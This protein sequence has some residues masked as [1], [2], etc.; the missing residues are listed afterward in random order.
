M[1]SSH[2]NE[3]VFFLRAHKGF[4]KRVLGGAASASTE[5]LLSK[6]RLAAV[7]VPEEQFVALVDGPYG[8]SYSDFAAFDTTVLVAGSTGVTFTL[9]ILLDIAYRASTQRLPL[10]SLVFIWM[11]KNTEWAVW[12]VHELQDAV[13]KLHAVG[14]E[15]EVKIYVTC[16]PSFTEEA[17]DTRKCGCDCDVRQGPCCCDT[18]LDDGDNDDVDDTGSRA[19]ND[20]IAPVEF[21]SS[22]CGGSNPPSISDENP[23]LISPIPTLVPST[24]KIKASSRFRTRATHPLKDRLEKCSTLHSG[25]PN[26]KALLWDVLDKSQGETGIAVCG[27]PALSTTIRNTVSAVSDQRGANK[28]TGAGGVYL[29]SE[30]Y[31][32]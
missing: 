30:C 16:D 26:F 23:D 20:A 27:P 19:L 4:T 8:A 6:E 28:G 7:P 13:E 32:W 5:T 9:P 25:R 24:E 14:I 12:I 21:K 10:R 18:S 29:H 15:V 17:E 2:S 1:P 22:C 11:I 3:L 31:Y